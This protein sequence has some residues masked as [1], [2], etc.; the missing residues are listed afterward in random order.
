MQHRM[1]DHHAV[2][3]MSA[4]APSLCWCGAVRPD[5]V[6]A[7]PPCDWCDDADELG[8]PGPWWHRG[9]CRFV[10]WWLVGKSG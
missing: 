3:P 8:A 10:T 1:R 5:P 2:T 7:E 6:H 9:W 4:L